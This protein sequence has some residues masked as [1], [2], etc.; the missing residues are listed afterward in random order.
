M[1]FSLQVFIPE[2]RMLPP[3]D[4]AMCLPI[5]WEVRLPFGPWDLYRPLIHQASKAVPALAGMVAD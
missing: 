5:E 3:R 1:P 4:T 2:G